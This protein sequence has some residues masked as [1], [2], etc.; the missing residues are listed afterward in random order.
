MNIFNRL[1]IFQSKNSNIDLFR[2]IIHYSIQKIKV[3]SPA[4]I[5]SYLF[6]KNWGTTFGQ[7]VR[8][9][10]LPININVGKDFN[11]YDNCVFEFSES[12]IVSVGDGVLF[13]YG[14]VFSCRKRIIIGNFVQIGEYTSI[15]D[16]THNYSSENIPIKFADDLLEDIIIGNNVWI[17]RG[18]IILPGTIIEDGV[19]VGANSVV[20]G[21]L[22][23]NWIYAGNPLK[24]IKPRIK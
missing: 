23:M 19:V 7:N 10:G 8:F 15:R 14:V 13:S 24:K 21:K 6:F 20:K 22:E 17:G 4:F 9:K 1:L 16:S 18:C 12:S 5:K 3:L 11:I 2:K